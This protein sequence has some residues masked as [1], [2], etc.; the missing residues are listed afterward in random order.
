MEKHER[1]VTQHE[2]QR[3]LQS[4]FQNEKREIVPENFTELLNDAKPYDQDAL[5]IK[6]DKKFTP[7]QIIMKMQT[8]KD[9]EKIT[10]ARKQIT[11]ISRTEAGSQQQNVLR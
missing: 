6:Q 10:K 11:L 3:D 9:E 8:T 1:K 4:E 7:R 2:G 5:N